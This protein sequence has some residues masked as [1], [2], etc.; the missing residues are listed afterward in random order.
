MTFIFNYNCKSFG[1]HQPI[2][3]CHI[4]LL[5][6]FIVKSIHLNTPNN[7]SKKKKKNYFTFFLKSQ[8]VL[9]SR[10]S[11]H[12]PCQISVCHR[13]ISPNL[14][15]PPHYLTEQPIKNQYNSVFTY[16]HVKSEHT[17]SPNWRSHLKPTETEMCFYMTKLK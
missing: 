11:N 9:N 2:R 1:L 4:R 12:N 7:I 14:H 6:K 16:C 17:A 8:S 5:L 3:T 13:T 15:L 10:V